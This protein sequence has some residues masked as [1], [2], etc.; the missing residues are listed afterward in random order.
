M[1]DV[2]IIGSGPAGMTAAVYTSRKRL[3]VLIISENVGGQAM[4]SSEIDN[5]LGYK[6]ITGEE[7]VE[8]FSEHIN[9]FGIKQE[10]AQVTSLRVEDGI[11]TVGACN[12]GEFKAKSVIIASGKTPRM[13]G[14]PGEKEY[15]GKGVAYCAT[16]DAPMFEGLDV[17][18]AG[19]GNSALD[20]A[21]QL[22]KIAR[23]V[24]IIEKGPRLI[25]D[26]IFRDKVTAAPNVEILTGTTIVEIRGS[27]FMESVVVEDGA[28]G[29]RRTLPARG[30]F[31]EIGS[32]PATSYLKDI[33]DLNA[34]NEVIVNCA[35]HTSLPGLFAAGD[36]TSVPEKQ[37][38][39][40]AGEG[41]KAALASYKYLIKLRR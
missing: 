23:K 10:F 14:V 36:V 21:I 11:F 39:I 8:K 29:E 19:G 13:L 25:A 24:T 30:V 34:N 15:L 31:I 22:M 41:A 20:A 2:I 33:V 37:V 40:A 18:V 7:L 3:D 16:C 6:Y 32:I 5:Y 35:C 9:S 12:G 26:E 1:Y 27:K 28:S 38:I 17:A 4:Y